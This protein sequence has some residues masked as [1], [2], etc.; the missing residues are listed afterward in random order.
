MKFFTVL[1]SIALFTSSTAFAVARRGNDRFLITD[2]N[3]HQTPPFVCRGELEKRFVYFYALEKALDVQRDKRIS[4]PEVLECNPVVLASMIRYF[5]NHERS[6]A[7]FRE[8]IADGFSK[9]K[10]QQ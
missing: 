9:F 1:I 2:Y 3:P 10:R 8:N 6:D 4:T 7:T 5:Y